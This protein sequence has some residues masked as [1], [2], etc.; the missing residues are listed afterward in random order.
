LDKPGV[1]FTG[2]VGSITAHVNVGLLEKKI[3]DLLRSLL[4]SVLYVDLLRSVSRK[5]CDQFE[6]VS[7]DLLAF[8]EKRE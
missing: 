8:L 7:E 5:G 4:E 6:L 1:H 2:H 3:I